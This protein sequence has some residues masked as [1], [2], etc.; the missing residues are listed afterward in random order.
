MEK[1]K[2]DYVTQ[3][4]EMF[5]RHVE[6]GKNTKEAK[7]PDLWMPFFSNEPPHT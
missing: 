4:S 7:N 6:G 3:Q 1:N 2:L 5:K